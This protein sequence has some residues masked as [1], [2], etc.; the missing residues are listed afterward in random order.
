[1]ADRSN[2]VLAS[3]F[4]ISA[5]IPQDL[6]CIFLR[7]PILFLNE[8]RRFYIYLEIHHH[9]KITHCT[10]QKKIKHNSC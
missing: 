2:M 9:K 7:Q 4:D 8:M 10:N 1:M 5:C 6:L 3:V